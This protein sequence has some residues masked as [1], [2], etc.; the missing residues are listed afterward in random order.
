MW[1]THPTHGRNSTGL[2]EICHNEAA[3]GPE[4]DINLKQMDGCTM[5]LICNSHSTTHYFKKTF[6][7]RTFTKEMILNFQTLIG[8]NLI[9]TL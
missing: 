2:I 5:E 3:P 1:R 7:L 8:N 4:L 9:S 6:C